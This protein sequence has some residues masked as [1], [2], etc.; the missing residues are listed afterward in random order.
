MQHI[1][2]EIKSKYPGVNVRAERIS[3]G[4]YNP[5]YDDAPVSDPNAPPPPI[6][7]FVTEDDTVAVKN[8]NLD[9]LP[10]FLAHLIDISNDR[11]ADVFNGYMKRQVP[12]HA[13]AEDFVNNIVTT[14]VNAIE[15]WEL[16]NGRDPS[17]T[18]KDVMPPELLTHPKH[19]EGLQHM[20]DHIARFKE[21]YP[22]ESV[23]LKYGSKEFDT[24]AKETEKNG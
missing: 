21:L 14:T 22:N 3:L 6:E 24:D 23:V 7:T 10:I 2:D 20:K 11:M 13:V 19:Q 15:M 5:E 12:V 9:D 18:L 17:V 1:V 8:V 16:L 4:D